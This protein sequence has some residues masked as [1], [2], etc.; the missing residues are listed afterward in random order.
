MAGKLYSK[1]GMNISVRPVSAE[2]KQATLKPI[3]D[4]LVK[5]AAEIAQENY[6]LGNS[7]ALQESLD[8]A[9]KTAPA[10][11]AQFSKLADAAIKESA[12]KLPSYVKRKLMNNF[13][14]AKQKYM[15]KVETNYYD[16]IDTQH[17][18][19]VHKSSELATNDALAQVDTLYQAVINRDDT[20]A[21]IALDAYNNARKKLITLSESK[22][23][24]G[25]YIYN[26][27]ERK[28]AQNSQTGHLEAFKRHIDTLSK[29]ELKSFDSE[30]F[31]DKL[32]FQQKTG[33]DDKTYSDMSKYI[34]GRRKDLGDED[35]RVIKSQASFAASR[36]MAQRDPEE[37]AELRKSGLV[38]KRTLDAIDKVYKTAPSTKKVAD[39]FVLEKTL[40]HLHDVVGSFDPKLDDSTNIQDAI[41][42]FGDSF[43]QFSNDNGLD[44]QQQQEVLDMATK[45]ISDS[46]FRDSMQG[47]FADTAISERIKGK[48]FENPY[49]PNY[50][51]YTRKTQKFGDKK[52]AEQDAQVVAHEYTRA[53]ALNAMAGNYDKANNI[54]QEGN[55]AVIITAN[56]DKIPAGEFE[57]MEKDLENGRPAYYTMQDGRTIEFCGY[58]N[59]DCIFK[60]KM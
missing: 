22:N 6:A 16:A 43:E 19:S 44:Q 25:K 53:W 49:S 45:Y 4:V 13:V 10:S 48:D 35:K 54:L 32:L 57:R 56:S 42:R 1:Q 37:Y 18:D 55:R 31:Q 5:H 51:I 9:Y 41:V 28:S 33:A 26:E 47:L 12:D 2:I 14:L 20:N 59:K 58:S 21:S 3:S 17:T 38:D 60:I 11:P 40:T 23:I 39:A 27:Q 24:K 34:E 8:Y 15:A 46:M 29:D 50:H 30:I 7:I 52:R 36:L